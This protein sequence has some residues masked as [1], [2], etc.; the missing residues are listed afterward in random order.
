MKNQKAMGLY[1]LENMDCECEIRRYMGGKVIIIGC[2]NHP[3]FSEYV[4]PTCGK[5]YR[6]RQQLKDCQWSHVLSTHPKTLQYI[7]IDAK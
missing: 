1:S 6:K 2:E 3:G 5:K 7:R 4:C